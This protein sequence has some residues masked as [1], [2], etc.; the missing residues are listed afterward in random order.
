MKTLITVVL[1]AGSLM[2]AQEEQSL[3]VRAVTHAVQEYNTGVATHCSGSSN[4]V[5]PTLTTHSVHCN[6]A[7]TGGFNA[8]NIVEANGMLYTITCGLR[9]TGT[10][11]DTQLLWKRCK[12]LIDGDTFPATINGHTMRIHGRKGGNQGKPVW[13]KY[14]ILD[15]RPVPEALRPKLPQLTLTKN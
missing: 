12:W 9:S 1:C 3:V 13:I 5:S 6:S 2:A 14:R 10:I 4:E 11:F 8:V 7:N 15:I